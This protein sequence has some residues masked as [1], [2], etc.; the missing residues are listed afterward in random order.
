MPSLLLQTLFNGTDDKQPPPWSVSDWL[1]PTISWPIAA[2]LPPSVCSPAPTKRKSTPAHSE[3]YS[4]PWNNKPTTIWIGTQ[5]ESLA[6]RANQQ[7]PLIQI[8]EDATGSPYLRLCWRR[9]WLKRDHIYATRSPILY[10]RGAF[11]SP[12][13]RIIEVKRTTM[14]AE[15]GCVDL[16]NASHISHPNF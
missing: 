7:L 4:S 14:N 15:Y 9:R 8:H 11:L 1:P 3:T 12:E 13:K 2:L 10:L 5:L 16:C 6:G